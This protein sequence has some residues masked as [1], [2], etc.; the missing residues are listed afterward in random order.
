[1]ESNQPMESN[2]LIESKQPMESNQPDGIQ[3][4]RWNLIN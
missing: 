3:S 2:Q 1:M 4:I